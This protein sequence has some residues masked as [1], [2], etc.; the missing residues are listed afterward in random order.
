MPTLEGFAISLLQMVVGSMNRIVQGFLKKRM[1]EFLSAY[2]W[3]IYGTRSKALG[4]E[5][6]EFSPLALSQYVGHSR[7]RRELHQAQKKATCER[8]ASEN[9]I[10]ISLRDVESPLIDKSHLGPNSFLSN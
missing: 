2:F 8:E 4:G 5:S 1:D 6:S 3:S 10:E 9:D 7:R